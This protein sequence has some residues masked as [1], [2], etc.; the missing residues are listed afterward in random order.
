MIKYLL[1]LLL[2]S[3]ATFKVGDCVRE[4]GYKAPQVITVVSSGTI[5]TSEIKDGYLRTFKDKQIDTLVSIKCEESI[6]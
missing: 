4:L 6:K 1:P 5:E 2:T 3:C